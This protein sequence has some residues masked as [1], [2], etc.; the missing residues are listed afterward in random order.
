LS[1]KKYQ[2]FVSSTFSDLADERQ[3][4]V[5]AILDSDHI[6]SGMELFPAIDMEQFEYIKKVIDECDYYILIIGARYGSTDKDGVSY[7]ERE[8][9]YAVLTGKTVIALIH[10]DIDNLPKKDFDDDPKLTERLK[11]FR[12]KVKN[13]RMVKLWKNRDQFIA[14][15]MQAIPKAISV[16]PAVGWIRGDQAASEDM[17]DKY[18]ELVAKYEELQE[19]YQ[20]LSKRNT[21]VIEG[22]ALLEEEFSLPFKYKIYND[23]RG[24]VLKLTWAQIF[25]ILGR[26]CYSPAFS[27]II[28][29]NLAKF[30]V[31]RDGTRRNIEFDVIQ[32]GQIKFHLV[33][34][35]LLEIVVG[36][37]SDMIR[38]TDRGKSE[39]IRLMAVRS[40]KGAAES[41][42]EAPS[43][44]Q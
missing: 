4:A 3:L 21:P 29:D 42:R 44:N 39:L 1:T 10:N 40:K 38:L 32:L 23:V 7:T 15:L 36:S 6:P 17:K 2:F 8:F 18:I 31:D 28:S 19:T 20:K 37:G 24:D 33:A 43:E 22:L 13:G 16:Y 35:K 9:D 14:A 5:K 27:E 41:E 34:L 25:I 26:S 30:I 12:D 11:V